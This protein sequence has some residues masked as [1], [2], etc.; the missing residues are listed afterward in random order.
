MTN[1]KS[2]VNGHF[3]DLLNCMDARKPITVFLQDNGAEKLLFHGLAYELLNDGEFLKKYSSFEI[4]GVTFCF[5]SVSVLIYDRFEE[6]KRQ[7]NK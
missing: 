5:N 1:T 7:A 6:Y 2:K 3:D 4:N